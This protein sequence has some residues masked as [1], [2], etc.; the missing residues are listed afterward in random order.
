MD[1]EDRITHQLDTLATAVE[2]G[3]GD[4]RAVMRRGR[5]RQARRRGAVALTTVA[6]LVAGTAGVVELKLQHHDRQAVVPAAGLSI[7]PSAL[8]WRTVQPT[9]SL[10]YAWGAVSSDG[11]TLAA[12][13]T[14][15]GKAKDGTNPSQS[16]YTSSDGVEWTPHTLNDAQ[17][18]RALDVFGGRIY[19]VGTAPAAAGMEAVLGTSSTGDQWSHVT[20]PVDTTAVQAAFGKSFL[21]QPSVAV[22]SSA[23]VASVSVMGALDEAKLRSLGV[24][25]SGGWRPTATGIDVLGTIDQTT[26]EQCKRAMSGADSAS[27]TSAPAPQPP[28][29]ASGDPKSA[30]VRAVT[31]DSLP[32]ECA[33]LK[34]GPPVVSSLTWAQL[35]I[36]P[37]LAPAIEGV[38]HVLVAVD[39][40][41]FHEVTLPV[42]AGESLHSVELHRIGDRFAA[43]AGVGGL[44]TY[45]PHSIVYASTDGEHW[46]AVPGAPFGGDGNNAVAAIGAL[47]DRI[48]AVTWQPGERGVQHLALVTTDGTG[49]STTDLT[50]VVASSGATTTATGYVAAAAIGQHGVTLAVSTYDDAEHGVLLDSPDGTTWSATPLSSLVAE[51]AISV[52]S[53]VDT[54]TGVALTVTLQRKQADGS[55]AQTS[56]VGAR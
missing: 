15:P 4:A 19:A 17:S 40:K 9:S 48:A 21:T 24:D 33:V 26:A 23:T 28:D 6:G 49:W 36:D 12:L 18:Y 30:Q 13:S 27:S 10:G 55:R 42:P 45:K 3:N 35:G 43:V 44:G 11:S 5:R 31:A 29:S 51:P 53:V 14:E 8:R 54:P 22:G 56:Y 32:P 50:S 38:A 39:G 34:D 16:L 7:A 47:G 41:S 46:I 25:P 52:S 2:P 37:Q 20:L 1:L